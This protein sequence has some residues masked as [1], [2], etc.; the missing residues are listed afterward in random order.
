MIVIAKIAVKKKESVNLMPTKP[1]KPLAKN[2]KRTYKINFSKL[3]VI[4]KFKN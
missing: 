1:K 2:I 3:Q 4:K